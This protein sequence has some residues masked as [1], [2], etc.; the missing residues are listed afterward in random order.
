MS[1][2]PY[3]P[4]RPPAERIGVRITESALPRHAPLDLYAEL[5]RELGPDEVYLMESLDETGRQRGPA[6]V[7]YGRVAE[8][9]VHPRHVEIE[10]P[11]ALLPWLAGCA[12]A[13]GLTLVFDVERGTEGA[14]RW[15]IGGP[16]QVWELL[17]RVRLLFHP[18]TGPP[19]TGY[20]FGFLTTIGYEA[21]WHME[22]LP[23]RGSR[24]DLPDLILTLFRDTVR[25]DPAGSAPRLRSADPLRA[26][27]PPD[28]DG[29][30]GLFG[31]RPDLD[32][33]AL[34]H[35]AAATPA[36]DVPT[37][38]RP[39][40]VRDSVTREE[41]LG[42]S[43]RCLEHIRVGDIYQIQIGHRVDVRT[44]ARPLEVY[45][46]LRGRN[47]SPHMYLLPR[48]G[49]LLIGASPELFFRTEGGEITMRPIA[50]TTRRGADPQENERRIKEM[51]ASSKEQA[52]HIMLVDLCRNDIGRVCR[53]G[54]LPVDRLMAV[55]TFSHV[56]HLVSTVT[57]GLETGVTVWDAVR[58]TFPAGTM[59]GAP[60]IRAMEIIA[61]L[62]RE[63]RGSYAGAVGLV[64]VR[65]WSEF[66]L[67]IRTISFDGGT[68]STQ[69]SAGIVAESRPE[70]EW[71]ETLAK[72]AAA[73]WALTGR[74]S[75]EETDGNG[76]L[77]A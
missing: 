51:R 12:E 11:E 27:G 38:P 44:E 72:M 56:F 47:P 60:K 25:Y 18:V 15:R 30:T 42:W 29:P 26:D 57:G 53:P 76:E 71:D 10:G 4:G 23:A 43:R 68:Y 70:A 40:S 35:R 77:T 69:S 24:P 13:A 21:A 64:D 5:S 9:R 17:E 7:G 73:H 6:V 28:R 63:P 2:L 41:F 22:E 19:A 58:A 75:V 46:R 52:E 67:C 66:A 49:G 61:G 39:T 55:E 36:V 33:M 48:A 62:E 45:R 1:P 16:E 34:A 54:T 31:S 8:I 59:S 50:G 37:A 74:D 65:G 14:A 3:S 20:L 32:P